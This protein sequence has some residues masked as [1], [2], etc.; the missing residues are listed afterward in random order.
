MSLNYNL[1]SIKQFD[2]LCYKRDNAVPKEQWTDNHGWL[3]NPITN[4]IIW[5]TIAVEMG[6]ITE[7]NVNEFY[8][9]MKFIEKFQQYK[10]L[11]TTRKDGKPGRG[12]NPS[13]NDIIRHIGLKTNVSTKTRGQFLTTQIKKMSEML[14]E[15]LAQQTVKEQINGRMQRK[16]QSKQL[17]I[18]SL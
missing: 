4:G 14:D 18:T 8:W 6:E 10:I 3:M 15:S 17:K 1:T 11:I 12:F 9:R 5:L 7:Q 16:G 13:L 2:K